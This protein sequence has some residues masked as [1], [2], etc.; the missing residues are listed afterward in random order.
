M[1]FLT[2]EQQAA[3]DAEEARLE[4]LYEANRNS[5]GPVYAPV[6]Q[7]EQ[8]DINM[9]EQAEEE[10]IN[11]RMHQENITWAK[12]NGLWDYE[13][14]DFIPDDSPAGEFRSA[15]R[16]R[17]EERK[18]RELVYYNEE[19]KGMAS[20]GPAGTSEFYLENPDLKQTSYFAPEN[21]AT[22]DTRDWEEIKEDFVSGKD[23]GPV[24]H[25]PYQGY[26]LDYRDTVFEFMYGD[27]YTE[28]GGSI[29]YNMIGVPDYYTNQYRVPY[30]SPEGKDFVMDVPPTMGG[31]KSKADEFYIESLNR[32]LE[33]ATTD[34]ERAEIQS[35]INRGAPTFSTREDFQSY[36]DLGVEVAQNKKELLDSGVAEA[37]IP[38][39]AKSELKDALQI[40]EDY[41][42]SWIYFGDGRNTWAQKDSG[43]LFFKD[44]MAYKTHKEG[45]AYLNT[46]TGFTRT[47][48]ESFLEDPD[49]FLGGKAGSDDTYWIRRPELIEE[50][51]FVKGMDIVMDVA[52]ILAPPAAPIIQAGK[53]ATAG[54]DLDDVLKAGVGTWLAGEIS[55]IAF[56]DVIETYVDMG[57]PVD[58]LSEV[59]QKVIVDTTIDGLQGKSIQDSFEKNAGKALVKGGA[60]AVGEILSDIDIE[61]GGEFETPEWLEKAGD[62][63]VATG[64][65][66]GDFVEPVTKEVVD[67]AQKGVDVVQE[68]VQPISDFT[69]DVEDDI[70]DAGRA[71]D[72]TVIDPIDDV[73]DTFGEEVVDPVLQAGSDVLSDAE[74][75]VSDVLSEGEDLLKEAGYVIDDLV[76]WESLLKNHFASEGSGAKTPT[77][78]LFEGEIYKTPLKQSPDKIFSDEAIAGFLN[79]EKN[80]NTEN[81]NS[82]SSLLFSDPKNTEEEKLKAS[83]RKRQNIRKGL[84][85]SSNQR[86]NGLFL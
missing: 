76:D 27:A 39:S 40:Q 33:K 78:S 15:V 18:A 11:A 4:A 49:W 64:K 46:G 41:M 10:E 85:S 72:D 83:A 63:V 73:I 29:G 69:S 48:L 26:G 24:M 36:Y 86:I 19:R 57:I 42:A 28:G 74:D 17:E 79:R 66:I 6:G 54:G 75:V 82:I 2:P 56:D 53:V 81:Q 59:Q 77:E 70:L 65:A 67:I 84:L 23:D 16:K 80:K 21:K 50:S 9:A 58:K 32:S 13:K 51:S 47:S 8:A 20:T 3:K 37:D 68:A 44:P 12:D 43:H 31:A 45:D 52:S 1:F 55:D 14:N 62:V 30:D 61:I 38:F 71:F 7:K 60:D 35:L 22:G 34:Q 5:G 25:N